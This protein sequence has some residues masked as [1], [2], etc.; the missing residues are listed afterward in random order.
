MIGSPLTAGILAEV[1]HERILQDNK[2]GEQNHEPFTYLAILG[3]EVGESN[4]AA[5]D[6]N[7]WRKPE[8]RYKFD[9]EALE[10]YRAELIQVAA[11]AVAAVECIDR[12][13]WDNLKK[14]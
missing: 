6:A 14:V 9:V 12:A 13:K 2:W 1:E 3:E 10:K 11:V 8:D 4:Q 5:L 7:N